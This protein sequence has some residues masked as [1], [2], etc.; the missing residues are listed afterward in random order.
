M[1]DLWISPFKDPQYILARIHVLSFGVIPKWRQ[2]DLNMR[3]FAV[4][5]LVEMNLDDPVIVDL[6]C[7]TNRVLGDF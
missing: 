4:D 3:L 5:S 1:T 2:Y 6:Q 7:L